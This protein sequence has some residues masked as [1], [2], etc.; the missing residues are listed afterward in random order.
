MNIRSNKQILSE[1]NRIR[2]MMNLTL[3]NEGV[4]DDASRKALKALGYTD[5]FIDELVGKISDDIDISKLA[6]EFATAGIKSSDDFLKAAAER[7]GVEIADLSDEAILSYV[8]SNDTI[9]KSILDKIS[10]LSKEAAQSAIR[11]MDAAKLFDA[12]SRLKSVID[13]ILSRPIDDVDL[14]ADIDE[15]LVIIDNITADLVDSGIAPPE[16]LKGLRTQL[17]SLGDSAELSKIRSGNL[18]GFVD[19]VVDDVTDDV[20]DDAEQ[21]YRQK[22]EEIRLQ[23][24]YETLKDTKLDDLI[25]KLGDSEAFKSAFS[26]F[27]TLMKKI[28]MGDASKYLDR[29]EKEL[30][31]KT[32]SQ[33]EDPNVLKPYTNELFRKAQEKL[34]KE[35]ATAFMKK[36]GNFMKAL[37]EFLKKIPLIGRF[38]KLFSAICGGAFLFWAADNID[39]VN[40]FFKRSFRE[41]FDFF[42][43]IIP[44][45]DFE[46]TL[47]YCY[48]EIDDYADLTDEEQIQFQGLGFNCDNVDPTKP[49]TLITKIEHVNANVAMGTKESFK[50]TIGGQE[51]TYEVGVVTPPNPPTPNPP[52]PNP[53]TP[54]TNKTLAEFQTYVNGKIAQNPGMAASNAREE[55]GYFIVDLTVNGQPAGP[56]KVKT[57]GSDWN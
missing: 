4:I 7:A 49:T 57:D 36:I 52:T 38:Y 19:N 28:G 18:N 12:D 16:S 20:T 23:K 11:D 35:G 24:E 17:K 30:G 47:P 13:D 14:K 21:A 10:A 53:P 40:N 26:Y 39:F 34:G 15:T 46:E 33:L 55:N 51:R 3:I 31:Q 8:K 56:A 43:N 37:D 48:F 9:M 22:Q 5:Q 25:K 29:A 44:G 54:G 1:V 27:D 32:L 41:L 6:D 45:A 50:V 2:E 42:D